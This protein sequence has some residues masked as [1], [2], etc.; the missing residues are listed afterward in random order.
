L[1]C[2]G[3]AIS[4]AVK[5]TNATGTWLR[6]NRAA[7]PSALTAM[8][9]AKP[10][11]AHY[12][13]GPRADVY[14]LNILGV[15]PAYGGRGIGRTLVA[16]GLERA[17]EQGIAASVVS[18]AGKERFYV[19]CGFE[20]VVGNV[21][22]GEGNPLASVRGGDILFRDRKEVRLVKEGVKDSSI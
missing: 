6:P 4:Q 15:D 8:T 18:A 14:D 12:F 3:L 11:F 21:T 20:E 13:Q 17:D 9:R 2:V 5:A 19:A 22:H 16:W 1:Y 10:F 7:D